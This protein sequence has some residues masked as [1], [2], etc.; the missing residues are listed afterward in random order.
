MSKNTDQV[1]EEVLAVYRD[2]IE[3]HPEIE[4]K[5][6]KKLP[7]TSLNGH[8]F[9]MVS[10]DGRVGFRMSKADREA[11]EEKFASG[12][13]TNYGAV[14]R[15][16]VTIPDDLLSNI[17]EVMPYLD[18]SYQYVQTLKPKPTKKKK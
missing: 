9:T 12:P 3:A 1:P 4:L 17:D 8:M 11:F 7:Y 5:G 13:F 16:Y 18:A 15:E 2:I 6:G 14:I 10:K